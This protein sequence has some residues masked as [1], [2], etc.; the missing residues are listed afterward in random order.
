MSTPQIMPSNINA[1]T[2][3]FDSVAEELGLPGPAPD[4]AFR[5]E[6]L[7]ISDPE[8]A[9]NPRTLPRP[10]PAAARRKN[11]RKTVVAKVQP[12]AGR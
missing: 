12:S 9:E 2:P 11:P 8:V 10:K 1:G 7:D 6:S 5:W 3:V 4:T